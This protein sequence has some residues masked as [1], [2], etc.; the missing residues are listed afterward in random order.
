MRQNV[1]GI[2][3]AGG[4]SSR[5][6]GGDK[7]LLPLG[8]NVVLDHVIRRFAPQVSA[9]ALSANGDPGRF[10]PFGLAVLPDEPA[11]ARQGPLAGLLAGLDWAA[12]EGA[13]VL[14]TAPGDTPFLPA[15]LG[16]RLAP[17]P[18]FAACDGQDHP[19]IGLWPV[20]SRADL[21]AWLATQVSRAVRGFIQRIGAT[22]RVFP[23]GCRD[24]FLNVNAPADLAAARARA[25]EPGPPPQR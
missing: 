4:R 3:L 24:G 16:A 5:M 15:G 17:A 7:S 20:E 12:G 13:E 18:G 25:A 11:F 19:L 21:R 22:R 23:P 2:I 1:A 8:P 14:L 6:G 9:L 10:A